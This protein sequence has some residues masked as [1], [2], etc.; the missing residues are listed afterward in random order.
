MVVDVVP[1]PFCGQAWTK[2]LSLPVNPSPA[3]HQL[4]YVGENLKHT[5]SEL[6]IGILFSRKSLL[7]N[8]LFDSH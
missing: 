7:R 2:A 3:N 4:W 1:L 5:S 6:V 8:V